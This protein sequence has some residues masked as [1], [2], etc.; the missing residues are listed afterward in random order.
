MTS[1]VPPLKPW[2]HNTVESIIY[3]YHFKVATCLNQTVQCYST[4]ANDKKNLLM[5]LL[6][7]H[8]ITQYKQ[9]VANGLTKQYSITITV[10]LTLLCM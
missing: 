7:N 6:S 2:Q 8:G 5:S 4:G 10:S 3:Q 9:L 1:D